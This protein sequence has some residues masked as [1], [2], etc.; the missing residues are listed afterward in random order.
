[1]GAESQH[2]NAPPSTVRDTPPAPQGE[3]RWQRS[4]LFD[5]PA[6]RSD[7]QIEELR[8][9][10][11]VFVDPQAFVEAEL[12]S[13][14]ETA[15]YRLRGS[16]LT[17]VLRHGSRDLGVLDEVFRRRYYALP[18]PVT[19][20]L[21]SLG[22]PPAAVDLGAHIGL[23]GVWL[24]EHY[25]G[26]RITAFEPDRFNF[27][28]LERC[29]EENAGRMRCDPVQAVAATS[30]G[31]VPFVEGD[32]STS[33]PGSEEESGAG[34][35]DQVDVLPHLVEADLLKADVEGGEWPVLADP[36]LRDTRV[37]AL[38]L[39]YHPYDGPEEDPRP[40]VERLLADAGF[41]STE[42]LFHRSD[43][44]GMLWAWREEA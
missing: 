10:A 39:E 4:R 19:T 30:P 5:L 36:R 14:G 3:R 25:P 22:R 8:E 35:V 17:V 27:A 32:F 23:F 41:R 43:G 18:A 29:L 12:S 2:C 28:V 11:T 37:R 9:L 13:A 15:A 40:E 21:H 16:G 6:E 44:V 1:M 26:A 7:Q 33:R 31:T 20:I 38:V 34:E 24:T 42:R